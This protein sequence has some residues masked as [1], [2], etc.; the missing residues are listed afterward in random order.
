MDKPVHSFLLADDHS[1]VRSGLKALIR[2]N[3]AT[4]FIHEAEN[5]DEVVATVKKNYYDVIILDI[6][7]P[8]T[9]FLSLLGWL[10]STT[11]SSRVLIFTTHSEEVY[12]VRCL[13][14]GAS[15]FLNKTATNAEILSALLRVLDNRKYISADLA[16]LLLKKGTD[17]TDTNPF[18]VLSAREMEITM[19]LHKGKSLPEICE[20]LHIQYSTGNTYK[21]RIFEKLNVFNIVS[22]ERLIH[23][24]GVDE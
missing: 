16:E 17:N 2:D 12:G 7:M 24:H 13:Q 8:D 11:P 20:L 23:T 6:N 1:I 9:D 15:G 21:R 10:T 18:H 3:F 19:L 22:L 5:G 14:S 4:R